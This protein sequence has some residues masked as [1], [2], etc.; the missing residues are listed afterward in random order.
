MVQKNFFIWILVISIFLV[1][2]NPTS[3]LLGGLLKSLLGKPTSTACEKQT[4]NLV[5][6]GN[7]VLNISSVEIGQNSLLCYAKGYKTANCATPRITDNLIKSQCNGQKKCA[8]NVN[9]TLFGSSCMGESR[10]L[11]STYSCETK[12]IDCSSNPC[13]Y[14]A[15]CRNGLLNPTCTCPTGTSGDPL[16]R[17]CKP[18]SCSCFGDPHCTTF[19][20]G[21]F[22]F[23]GQCKYD[24]V[25]TECNGNKLPADLIPFSVKQKQER[26]GTGP[27]ANKVSYIRFVEIN[28]FGNQYSLLKSTNNRLSFTVNGKAMTNSYKDDFNGLRVYVSAGNIVFATDFGLMVKWN[29]VHKA[30]VT[31]CN[32]YSKYVCGLCGNAD[33]NRTNDFVDR[34]NRLVDTSSKDYYTRFFN[35]GSKW[36]VPDDTVDGSQLDECVPEKDPGKPEPINC[37]NDYSTS[38]WCGLIKDRNGPWRSCILSLS[39]EILNNLYDSCMFDMCALEGNST[40]QNEYKCKAYEELTDKCYESISSLS[41]INWRTL[42]GCPITCGPNQIYSKPS[43]LSCPKTCQFP[44]GNYDCGILTPS[45]GCYCSSSTVL[46]SNGNCVAPS[47]CGCNLPEDMGIL[48]VGETLKS[49]DC[50]MKYSCLKPRTNVTIELLSACDDN[51]ECVG[52]ENNQAVC[53]CKDG[54]RGDGFTCEKIEDMEFIEITEKPTTTSTTTRAPTSTATTSTA[55]R[56]PTSTATTSTAS[57]APTSTATTST[58]RTTITTSI[59][60]TSKPVNFVKLME[61]KDQ[62]VCQDKQLDLDCSADTVLNILEANYGRSSL[63]ICSSLNS[64]NSLCS[65]ANVLSIVRNLC[66]NK[67]RCQINVHSSVFIKKCTNTNEYLHVRY[68]CLMRQPSN[69]PCANNPCGHGALCKNVNGLPVCSCPAGATGDAKVRCCKSLTCG[70]WGDPHCTTFDKAKFD[71][72]GRCKYDLVSTNCFNKTLPNGMIPFSVTQKQE[73]RFNRTNV[74]YVAHIYINVY[75]R[76]YRLLKKEKGKHKYTIDGLLSPNNYHDKLTGVKV[77]LSGGNLVFS[78][79]FGLTVTWNGDH[80]VDVTLCDT[81]ANYVCG[82][83]GNADGNRTN[84]F[85]DRNNKLVGTS[86]NDYY[87]RFFN[88]GSKWRVFDDSIDIDGKKCNGV[89]PGPEP[90]PV[91]CKNETLYQNDNWCGIIK[92]PLGPWSKCLSLIDSNVLDGIYDG[93]LF[94]LCASEGNSMLQL[95]FKCK[96][97]EQIADTC[98]G[99]LSTLLGTNWR[100]LLGCPKTCGLN[101]IYTI[102]KECPKTCM[103]PFGEDDCG[104][105]KFAEGCFCRNGYVLN[106]NGVCVLIEEC[107]CKLPEESGY[108]AVGETLQVDCDQKLKCLMSGQNVTIEFLQQC[109]MDALCIAGINNEPKCVCKDGYIGDGY[110]CRKITTEAPTTTTTTEAPT[111]TTTT[112]APTTTTSSEAPT[113]TTKYF[114]NLLDGDFTEEITTER[115][116]EPMTSEKLTTSTDAPITTTTTATERATSFFDENLLDGEFTEMTQTLISAQPKTTPKLGQLIVEYYEDN[117]T[118]NIITDFPITHG[119][120]TEMEYEYCQ[121]DSVCY[122]FGDPHYKTFDGR[123]FSIND[124]CPYI[125][126]TD[127]CPENAILNYLVIVNHENRFSNMKAFYMKTVAVLYNG[128]VYQLNKEFKVNGLSQTLPYESKFE[129]V[130]TERK[131]SY[132]IFSTKYFTLHFDGDE[133][134]KFHECSKAI[135]GICGNSNGIESD[136]YYALN[137]YI[138]RNGDARCF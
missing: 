82:L 41:Q 63:S 32:Y 127:F 6:Q 108:L 111:T 109:S 100:S 84:D 40:A 69:N 66:N 13:G 23:M 87:T 53:F 76:Q 119:N 102:K 42:A 15:Q 2:I 61:V 33:G 134:L 29:G 7:Q 116:I 62:F 64:S 19:D 105:L 123:K 8:I 114:E 16:Y 35:W 101:E 52:D 71:F 115:I 67:R 10:Y 122:G 55:S 21:K 90:E 30:E 128:K 70:C 130:K 38:K 112:E 125:L 65:P 103:D 74:A 43:V 91:I 77:F 20:G 137:R 126:A 118:I 80:K 81:Y 50:T 12:N 120:N 132:L 96:S 56:A 44:T 97:Y 27:N 24:L 78:T 136:D 89:D 45:E 4:L 48:G 131:D 28:V 26:R 83:C 5:C 22:D 88:W 25:T 17:C 36:R 9:S 51:A 95:E 94:D 107:G 59:T 79:Q 129:S 37:V 46:D 75:N 98:N 54:F 39:D 86:S 106:S 104:E 47:Q 72:M 138:V 57:R 1:N 60:T 117:S 73:Q 121:D 92:N 34:N 14:G 93:C 11:K 68:Q 110:D 18:I 113:T 135:C 99:L 49:P 31:L 124:T 58:T 85:V 133:L 3:A